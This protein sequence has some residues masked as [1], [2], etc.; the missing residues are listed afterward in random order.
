MEAGTV[1]QRGIHKRGRHVEAAPGTLEHPFHEVPD[2]LVRERDR[3]QLGFAVPGYVDLIGGVEPDFLDGGVVEE[4]LQGT[5]PGDGVED[6][7][8]GGLQRTD[9]RE[10]RQQGP[11]VVIRDRRFDEAPD[12]TGLPRGIEAAPAN[13]LADFVLDNAHS[14]HDGPQYDCRPVPGRC[15]WVKAK[16]AGARGQ[17]CP[18]SFVD[19]LPAA[20]PR[21][22]AG[23]AARSYF[24]VTP[25]VS[26]TAA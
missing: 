9:G 23:D 16:G 14:L 2:L 18:P 20:A 1:G 21:P 26:G 22:T 13:Q 24:A 7:P 19:K 8:P 11:L 4:G 3:R 6:K 15:N 17:G 5:E 10:G 12:L 25:E